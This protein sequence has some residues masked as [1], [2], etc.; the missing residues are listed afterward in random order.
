MKMALID[1]RAV[2]GVMTVE[3]A[4]TP[5]GGKLGNF[6]VGSVSTRVQIG[7]GSGGILTGKAQLT[8]DYGPG[9]WIWR[10]IPLHVSELTVAP[11]RYCLSVA[12]SR[13]G[14]K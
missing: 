5:N 4:L 10:I 6:Y 8:G 7:A 14:A 9:I 3:V 2:S 11:P 1:R 13:M 12:S